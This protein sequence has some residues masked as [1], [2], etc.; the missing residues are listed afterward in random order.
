MSTFAERQKARQERITTDKILEI[1]TRDGQFMVS[2]RYRDDWLRGRCKSL[3]DAGKLKRLKG[4]NRG[5]YVY[6]PRNNQG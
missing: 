4:I 5:H 2:L 1:A 6:V 3:C